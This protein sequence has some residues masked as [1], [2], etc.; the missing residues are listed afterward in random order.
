MIPFPEQMRATLQTTCMFSC[1]VAA[2]V[3]RWG[4]PAID[5]RFL[6]AESCAAIVRGGCYSKHRHYCLRR[7]G[8]SAARRVA[9]TLRLSR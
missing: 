3:V 7:Q 2:A 1:A 8:A 4:D 6:A 5:R 9:R